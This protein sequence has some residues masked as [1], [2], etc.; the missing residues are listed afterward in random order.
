MHTSAMVLTP[1][2]YIFVG[3]IRSTKKHLQYIKL[4]STSIVIKEKRYLITFREK[5]IGFLLKHLLF[6]LKPSFDWTQACGRKYRVSQKKGY[7][8]K[9]SVSAACSNLNALNP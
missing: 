5:G 4:A 2:F 6:W 1:R 8:L 7:P 9:S 3:R